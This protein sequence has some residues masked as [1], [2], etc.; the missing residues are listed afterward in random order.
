MFV[1][2]FFQLLNKIL[3][4]FITSWYKD[5]STNSDFQNEIKRCVRYTASVILAR[6]LQ[7]W[8]SLVI[9]F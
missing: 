7:V 4:E 6:G 8:M 5:V 9:I 2:F 3:D 1:F